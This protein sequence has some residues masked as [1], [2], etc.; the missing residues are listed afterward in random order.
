MRD[1]RSGKLAA[2]AGWSTTPAKRAHCMSSGRYRTMAAPAMEMAVLK[3]IKH[4]REF[5]MYVLPVV[6]KMT[7]TSCST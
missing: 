3:A 2:N 5:S 4:V 7:R 1:M 6:P